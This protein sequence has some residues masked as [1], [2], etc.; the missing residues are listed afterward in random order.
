M[1][2]HRSVRSAA[3]ARVGNAHQVGDSALQQLFRQRH[4]ADFGHP[5]ITLRPRTLQHHHRVLVDFQRR[6]VD[7]LLE[8]FDVGEHH[9]PA[10]ML[11]QTRA[12]PRKV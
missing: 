2:H 8:V 10:A 6:I 3:H 12:S 5:R 11:E 4:V 9:R 7:A 1:Q